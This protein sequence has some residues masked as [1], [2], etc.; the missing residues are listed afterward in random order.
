VPIRVV[1]IEDH[2]LMLKAIVQE[3]AGQDDIQV[4]GTSTH[5][6]DLQRLVRTA[7]P[8]VVVLDLGMSAGGFSPV[9]AVGELRQTHP[10]VQVL[11][12]TA[13]EDAV[14]IRRLVD[15]GARGYVLKSDDLSLSLPEGVRTVA[16]GRRFY[17]AT[18]AERFFACEEASG[19][20]DREFS[21]LELAA[22]GH[23]NSRI[24]EELGISEKTVRNHFSRVYNK[25]GITA[26]D[27]DSNP[28]VA[29]VNRARELGLLGT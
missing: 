6:G 17:S 5:G 29:V 19:L 8:D 27:G 22:R 10:H 28:R 24:G 2:P 23:S 15:A 9:T 11:V 16:A 12:L 7:S 21:V 20:T 13:Y 26:A 1:A 25:L 18:V 14:W 3:L 4:V